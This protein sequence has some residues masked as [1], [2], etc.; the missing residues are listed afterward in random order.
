M[1]TLPKLPSLSTS[2]RRV[3]QV[4]PLRDCA[5]GCGSSTKS[6]WHPGHDGHCDGWAKRVHEGRLVLADVPSSVRKG[7]VLRL[8]YHGWLDAV[9]E[10]GNPRQ[11]VAA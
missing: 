8:R 2:T 1:N 10:A 11:Q 5:C 6:T 7:V 3:R 4:K 9:V